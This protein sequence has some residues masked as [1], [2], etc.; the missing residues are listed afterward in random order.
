METTLLMNPKGYPTLPV[1]NL[2]KPAE[3]FPIEKGVFEIAPGLKNFGTSFGNGK[4]DEMVFQCDSDF[5]KFHSNKIS[6]RQENIGKYFGT[7]EFDSETRREICLFISR[8]LHLESP[9]LFNFIEFTNGGWKLKSQITGDTLSFLPDGNLDLESSSSNHGLVW[10]DGLDAL[11]CQIQ[12]DFAVL[13]V[14]PEKLNYLSAIHVCA[15]AHWAPDQKIGKDFFAIHAPIPGIQKVNSAAQHFSEAMV[16]KGPFVRF[17]WGFATDTQLNHHPDAPTGRKFSNPNN[18]QFF[19][20]VE[21]QVTWGLPQVNAALFTIRVSFIKGEDI[22]NDSLRRGQLKSALE[23]MS[24]DILAYK[25]LTG[26]IEP[27]LEWLTN[28]ANVN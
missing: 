14:T 13:K 12:E 5:V 20:R 19:L 3:Y 17:V 27:L 8:R 6:C 26:S 1:S 4:L 2:P 21:R 25:G 22:K 24:P 11:A 10:T 7:F 16:R 28:R 9:H 23:G 15:P 18:S